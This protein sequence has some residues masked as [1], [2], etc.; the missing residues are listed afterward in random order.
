MEDSTVHKG[1]TI[2][3]YAPNTDEVVLARYIRLCEC[4]KTMSDEESHP[5]D[6]Q[7]AEI[8]FKKLLGVSDL[9]LEGLRALSIQIA[10]ER[11]EYE[12]DGKDGL[13]Q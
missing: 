7:I 6:Y 13:T 3:E 10:H 11:M 9:E 8:D 12:K 5:H 4:Y 1:T 2:F